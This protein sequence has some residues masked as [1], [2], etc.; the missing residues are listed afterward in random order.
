MR[1]CACG[2][3]LDGN[4]KKKTRHKKGLQTKVS[5]AHTTARFP[6]FTT[7]A[8]HTFVIVTSMAKLQKSKKKK[9]KIIE[10]QK[11]TES[12]SGAKA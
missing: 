2:M 3:T 5:V 6:S 11:H 4:T 7:F 10:I 9:A 8:F 1:V 12:Q